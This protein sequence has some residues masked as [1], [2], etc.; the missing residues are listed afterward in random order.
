MY[1]TI[2]ICHYLNYF[3]WSNFYVKI[4]ISDIFKVLQSQLQVSTLFCLQ[5]N[6]LMGTTNLEIPCRNLPR[7]IAPTTKPWAAT[8]MWIRWTDILVFPLLFNLYSPYA[9]IAANPAIPVKPIVT[10]RSCKGAGNQNDFTINVLLTIII[11]ILYE[12]TN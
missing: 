6:L 12:T 11:R 5:R 1:Q 3:Y 2:K 9:T 4:N 7:V 10:S 8:R